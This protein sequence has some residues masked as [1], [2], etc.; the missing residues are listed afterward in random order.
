MNDHYDSLF[1]DETDNEFDIALDIINQTQGHADFSQLCKY[2]DINAW[3]NPS[4]MYQP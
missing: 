4:Q 1:F 2:H 3:V